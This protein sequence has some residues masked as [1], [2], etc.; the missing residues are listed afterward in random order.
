MEASQCSKDDSSAG[1]D[2]RLKITQAWSV[3][4]ILAAGAVVATVVALLEVLYYRRMF[5]GKRCR[6]HVCP[7]HGPYCGRLPR[8]QKHQDWFRVRPWPEKSFNMLIRRYMVCKTKKPAV[9]R[10]LWVC[11]WLVSPE[12]LCMWECAHLLPTTP[13]S[14]LHAC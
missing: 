7:L 3:F 5:A 1:G 11:R 6:M 9:F 14:S 8:R 4:L 12:L 2:G 10:S 13:P